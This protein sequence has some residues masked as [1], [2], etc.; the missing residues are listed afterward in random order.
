MNRDREYLLDA[1]HACTLI[2]E[3]SQ[4]QNQETFNR[5]LKTQ[6]SVLYQLT[7]LGEATNRLSLD[8]Q[9]LNPQVPIAAMRGMRNRIVHEYKEV[10]LKILWDVVQYHIPELLELLQNSN[11]PQL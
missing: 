11:L 2:L 3:F 1:I 4:G 9:T 7:I 10:D 6:S 5:D 8:Y